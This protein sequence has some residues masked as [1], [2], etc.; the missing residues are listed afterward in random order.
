M[1][2]KGDFTMYGAMDS[3][4]NVDTWH[5]SHP[6]D[7]DRFYRALAKIVRDPKFSA[8]QM[9]EYMREVKGV[10]GANEDNKV[11]SDVIDRRVTEAY[12]IRKFI[13]LGI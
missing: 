3:Y 10:H 11:F 2:L 5:T 1:Q 6:L 8:E 12:A 13:E 9:G 4:L 7:D